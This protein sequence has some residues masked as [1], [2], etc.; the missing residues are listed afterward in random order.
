MFFKAGRK[1]SAQECSQRSENY[2]KNVPGKEKIEYQTA[3]GYSGDS[4]KA[5][6][7]KNTQSFGYSELDGALGKS[8]SIGKTGERNV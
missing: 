1:Q 4:G 3:Y 8:E 5:D 6:G 2:V 7:W